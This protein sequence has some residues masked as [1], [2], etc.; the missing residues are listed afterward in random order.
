M[1]KAN[2]IKYN[3]IA[4]EGN[5]GAGKTTLCKLLA[6]DFNWRLILEQFSDNPFLPMFYKDPERHAFTVELFFM[7]ERFQQLSGDMVQKDLFQQNTISD[8]FFMKTLL[9]ANKTLNGEEYRLFQRLFDILSA[10]FPK[11]ELLVYLHRPIPTLLRNI[12]KRGRSYEQEIETEYLQNIQDAYFNYFKVEKSYP[13]LLIEVNDYDFINE[14][15]YY[16]EIISLLEEPYPNGLNRVK[17]SRKK[18]I[19][20]KKR[21]AM[22][23]G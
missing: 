8:Y 15:Y 21:V 18:K 16:Q 9:F 6:K 19:N 3:Y 13:I 20:G 1:N 10:N 12:E 23:R 7:S 11:P 4:I 14:P 17:I 22:K 2:K 5:I